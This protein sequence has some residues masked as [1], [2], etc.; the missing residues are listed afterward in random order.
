MG[1]T[2]PDREIANTRSQMVSSNAIRL[3]SIFLLGICAPWFHDRALADERVDFRSEIVPALTKLGCNAG[4]CHGSAVGRG[5][6][7]LSLYG[8]Q[9]DD[10]FRAIVRE[11]KG[12]RINLNDYTKSLLLRKPGGELEHGG[13]QRFSL[14]DPFGQLL[15]N[16]IQQGADPGQPS[17]LTAFG[18]GPQSLSFPKPG[19]EHPFRFQA[20]FAD[21]TQRDVTRLTILSSLDESSVTIDPVKNRA[22]ILRPGRHIVLA[23]F[24]DRVSPIE[25]LI[26]FDAVSP[27]FPKD[28]NPNLVDRYVDQKLGQ[29]NI[30]SSGQ[31][32]DLAFLRR[33][34][35]DLTGR[36]PTFEQAEAFLSDP[37]AEK[38]SQWIRK[39]LSGDEFVDFW[40]YQLAT[41]LR[42]RSQQG[43]AQAAFVYHSWLRN[44][45]AAE[46]SWKSISQDLLL[47][48]GDSLDNGPANFY[49]TTRDARLQSEFVSEV[50]LGVKLGCA[51]CH[52]HPLDHWTQDDYHGLAAIFSRVNQT[53]IVSLN[54]AGE[55]IHPRTGK[56]AVGR[57]PGE[58]FLESEEEDARV[59]LADWMFADSNPYFARAMVNRIWKSLMGRGLVDPVDDLRTT[60][61]ATH[62]E[63]LECLAEDFRSHDYDLR[64]TIELIC[65][66][67]AYQRETGAKQA[68]EFQEVYYAD[69]MIRPLQAEVLSDA[70]GDVTGVPEDYGGQNSGKR[71]IQL[72]DPRIPS[73]SLD[74]LGRCSREESCEGET[75]SGR[76]LASRLHLLNGPL[77]NHKITSR[78]SQLQTMIREGD[79]TSQIIQHFYQAAL[80][81]SPTAQELAFWIDTIDSD[82]N[83]RQQPLED[84]V[85]ALLTCKEFTTNH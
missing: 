65:N 17:R 81:R 33:I 37:H 12:R 68:P 13:E 52:N 40:T 84:F 53:Q 4:S 70:I 14:N 57:I 55:N 20:T 5:G 35:L 22:T 73:P 44:Q 34:S 80:T 76:G 25:I 69:R 72:H 2:I 82:K 49:R 10:D 8:S 85:W 60:N 56:P 66:S 46:K 71:A 50:F 61:P 75:D 15:A 11:S 45:M 6:F 63:L 59:P 36:L 83:D 79:S 54:P 31:V 16:W 27:S 48:L 51:N 41:Q 29:L 42:I 9:P 64:H 62:P 1:R 47:S 3:C 19:Q 23:R 67:R 18:T 38:R 32:E 30:P 24:M 7:K 21:G 39:Y 26:P 74:I 43:D 28:P 58:R 78:Q 77:L